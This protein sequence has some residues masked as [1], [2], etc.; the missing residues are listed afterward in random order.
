MLLDFVEIGVFNVTF[1]PT[2]QSLLAS[3]NVSLRSIA[4]LTNGFGAKTIGCVA[5]S[6]GQNWRAVTIASAGLAGHVSA[7]P[8]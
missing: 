3:R 1:L 7:T 6:A 5:L 4:A 8:G 2:A